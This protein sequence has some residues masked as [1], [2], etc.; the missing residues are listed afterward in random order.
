MDLITRLKLDNSQ[1][2]SGIDSAKEKT[3]QFQDTAEDTNKSLN[4]MGQKGAKSAKEL[5]SEMNK[6]ENAS[7]SAPNCIHRCQR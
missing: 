3:K 1:Y 2:N 5:L 4:D 6:L 7:R